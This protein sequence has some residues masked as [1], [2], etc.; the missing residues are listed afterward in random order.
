MQKQKFGLRSASVKHSKWCR[1][2]TYQSWKQYGRCVVKKVIYA[3]IILLWCKLHMAP[4]M[5]I[6]GYRYS[7]PLT[8]MQYILKRR[9]WCNPCKL[10][11]G[12][13]NLVSNAVCNAKLG[14]SLTSRGYNSMEICSEKQNLR[15]QWHETQPTQ[16]KPFVESVAFVSGWHACSSCQMC[17]RWTCKG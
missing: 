3:W 15:Y 12:S 14:Q 8:G 13:K 4:Q 9:M 5:P 1:S 10:S 16:H 2:P 11:C 7:R 17:T 6:R